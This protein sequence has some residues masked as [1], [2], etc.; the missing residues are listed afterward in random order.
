VKTIYQVA[1]LIASSDPI[2]PGLRF[3][4]LETRFTS[5][6]MRTRICEGRHATAAK[7]ADAIKEKEKHA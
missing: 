5:D 1:E 4:I 2:L 3:F 7:A 6:G